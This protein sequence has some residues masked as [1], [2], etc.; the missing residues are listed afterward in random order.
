MRRQTANLART[1]K[2]FSEVC[3]LRIP[4]QCNVVLR[5]RWVPGWPDGRN[6]QFRLLAIGP[7]HQ[8][9]VTRHAEHRRRPN[10]SIQIGSNFRAKFELVCEAG[11][12]ASR[13]TTVQ[14]LNLRR[15]ICK[16]SLNFFN[17]LTDHHLPSSCTSLTAVCSSCRAELAEQDNL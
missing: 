4:S 9:R 1:A 13:I 3:T 14:S 7:N 11:N 8:S 15:R 5:Q 12:R 6:L 2:V 10:C 16:A 17:P